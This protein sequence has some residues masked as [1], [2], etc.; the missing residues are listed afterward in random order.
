MKLFFLS[1]TKFEKDKPHE[2]WEQETLGMKHLWYHQCLPL[3]SLPLPSE[4][5][6]TPQMPV[7]YREQN[8]SLNI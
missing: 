1:A 8:E 6:L 4:I 2:Q 3:L 5:H 7:K